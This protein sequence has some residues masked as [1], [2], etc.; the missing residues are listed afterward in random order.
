M[1]R[2]LMPQE[3][4]N[5]IKLSQCDHGSHHWVEID[6]LLTFAYDFEVLQKKK[7]LKRMNET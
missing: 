5:F 7:Q 6:T 2:P 1:L 4:S 3:F